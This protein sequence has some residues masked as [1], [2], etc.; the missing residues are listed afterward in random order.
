[1]WRTHEAACGVAIALLVGGCTERSTPITASTAPPVERRADAEDAN[2]G[3][4]LVREFGPDVPIAYYDLSL[5]F[6]KQTAGITPP[7]QSRAFGYMGLA[8]YEALVRGMPDHRSVADQLN[9]IG[10]LPDARDIP[11]Q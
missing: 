8:L 4:P 5:Q 2:G 9:G 11:Y 1:M 7:V 3:P 10:P 6:A